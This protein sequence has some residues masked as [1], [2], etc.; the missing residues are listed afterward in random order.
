MRLDFFTEK[1]SRTPAAGPERSEAMTTKISCLLAHAEEALEKWTR[2]KPDRGR[3]THLPTSR[4]F[5]LAYWEGYRDALKQL[6]EVDET[7]PE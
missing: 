4:A 5:N 3:T 1:R 2:G 7:V 6:L